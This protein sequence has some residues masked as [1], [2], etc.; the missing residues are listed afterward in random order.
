MQPVAE[1]L[2]VVLRLL[3]VLH[4]EQDLGTINRGLT[5]PRADVRASSRELLESFVA[6]RLRDAVLGLV[7]DVPDEQRLLHSGAFHQPTRLGYVALLEQL[8][9]TRSDSLQSLAVYHIG[10]LGIAE[11]RGR[12][13]ALEPTPESSLATVVRQT[14]ALLRLAPEPTP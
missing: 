2:P 12:V 13:E 11:L 8:L 7:D 1:A 6:P 10:E 3:G 4:P 5:S 9:E 14:V